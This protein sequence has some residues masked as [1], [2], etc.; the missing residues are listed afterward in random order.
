MTTRSMIS[1]PN[2]ECCQNLQTIDFVSHLDNDVIVTY[3][4]DHDMCERYTWVLEFHSSCGCVPNQYPIPASIF[5]NTARC[6]NVTHWPV[7]R[8]IENFHCVNR[9]Q[10]NASLASTIKKNCAKEFPCNALTYDY[11]SSSSTWP[12][13]SLISWYLDN[14]F[15]PVQCTTNA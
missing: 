2:D 10:S 9:L 6:L 13:S 4:L 3:N 1:T 7:K 14:E 11:L 12:T 15:W 5:N 8:V